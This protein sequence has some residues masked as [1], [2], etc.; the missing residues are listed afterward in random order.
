[1]PD[2]NL[3]KLRKYKN[4]ISS[5]PFIIIIYREQGDV[6]QVSVHWK[7]CQAH[8]GNRADVSGLVVGLYQ[9]PSEFTQNANREDEN[10]LQW[11]A[12][13]NQDSLC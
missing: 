6:N 2:G 8:N 3:K 1:M 13:T 11:R 12:Q 10:V 9:L 5:Y 4:R 7:T